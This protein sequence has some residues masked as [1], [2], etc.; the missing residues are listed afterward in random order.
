M[1]E[2]PRMPDRRHPSALADFDDQMWPINFAIL[3][4]AGFVAGIVLAQGDFGEPRLLYN[5][6][7]H[8]A[9]LGG[10]LALGLFGARLLSGKIRRRLQ[11]CIVLSLTIHLSGAF[12]VYCHP[13]MLPIVA[14]A[15]GGSP[16]LPE[17]RDLPGE[18]DLIAPDYDAA[19]AEEPDAEKTFNRPVEAAVADVTPAA[20]AVE[21]PPLAQYVPGSG[22]PRA[23]GI[24]EPPA[25]SSSSTG[26]V[27]MPALPAVASRLVPQ[28]VAL[29]MNRRELAAVEMPGPEGD[30]PAPVEN[31]KAQAVAEAAPMVAERPA[32]ETA[33]TATPRPAAV[34]PGPEPSLPGSTL[35]TRLPS[36]GAIPRG[37]WR[38]VPE[39]ALSSQAMTVARAPLGGRALPSSVLPDEGE[40]SPAGAAA[41]SSPASRLKDT[42]TVAVEWTPRS[43]AP[44]GRTTS[45]AGTQYFGSGA[46]LLVARAGVP[47]GQGTGRPSIAGNWGEEQEALRAGAP[48]SLLD[49]G[50]SLPT[51]AAR[52]AV[53]SQPGGGGTALVPGAAATLPRTQR[54][55][56]LDLPTSV[57]PSEEPRLGGAGGLAATPGGATSNLEVGRIASVGRATAGATPGRIT[58]WL[59]LWIARPVPAR[60]PPRRSW[61][62][63]ASPARPRPDRD[64]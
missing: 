46:A 5:G 54:D 56:G 39:T 49:S 61:F 31:P 2:L 62:R 8:L 29:A 26:A 27:R 45:A 47:G 42:S 50:W 63:W 37:T 18:G 57:M 6:Y 16:D 48:G 34:R 28:V 9:L 12:Y 53:A 40:L 21:P 33:A 11:L 3:V 20:A 7:F 17:E 23:P 19:Q 58:P 22:A 14:A 43:R 55:R 13:L 24:E 51:A 15:G 36:A 32:R 38:N 1:S 52:R 64:A 30:A 59:L 44:S 4:L 35:A 60:V 25:G 10:M 41:G